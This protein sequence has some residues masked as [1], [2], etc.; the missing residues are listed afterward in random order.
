MVT[1]DL[2]SLAAD[3]E[4]ENINGQILLQ[5]KPRGFM[6]Y[7][8][9][10]FPVLQPKKLADGSDEVLPETRALRSCRFIRG[11]F[12]DAAQRLALSVSCCIKRRNSTRRGLRSVSSTRM[13]RSSWTD[14]ACRWAH[15]LP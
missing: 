1:F 13:P 8:V 4:Q 5:G 3:A 7:D 15:T 10:F 14:S 2:K 11:S 9:R 12:D 6:K